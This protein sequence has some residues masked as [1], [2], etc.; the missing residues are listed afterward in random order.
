MCKKV[1]V[2]TVQIAIEI[3][4]QDKAEDWISGLFENQNQLQGEFAEYTPYDWAYLRMGRQYLY[5]TDRL[6]DNDDQWN[7]ETLEV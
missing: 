1:Y 6:V 7:I 2:A 4:S 3:D 5:P